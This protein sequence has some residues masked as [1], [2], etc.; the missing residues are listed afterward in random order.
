MSEEKPPFDP[1]EAES[2]VEGEH[3]LRFEMETLE[4]GS[5]GEINDSNAD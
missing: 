5:G 1:E 2:V 3:G 4:K